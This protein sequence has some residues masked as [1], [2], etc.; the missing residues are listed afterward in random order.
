MADEVTAQTGDIGGTPMPREGEWVRR[1]WCVGVALGLIV[2]GAVMNVFYLFHHCPIDLSDDEAHYWM[3]AQQLDYG[4]YSKPPG[5]AFVIWV[6]Q[7]VGE[8]LGMTGDGSGA[9]LMPVIRMPAVLFGTLSG[10]LSW[11]LARRV[12]RDDRVG[13][14][15]IVLSAAV[16]MFAV[17]SLLIT[18]D[19][20]MY[21]CWA[22][23]VYCLWRVVSGQWSVA[24]GEGKGDRGK[25]IGGSGGRGRVVW[26]YAAGVCAAAGMMFK[27]VLIAVPL[28]AAV[29]AWGDG[30]MRRALKTWHALGAVAVMALSQVPVVVWNA[31]HGWVTFRHILTQ[32]GLS[33]QASTGGDSMLK[34]FGIF[35]GGQAGGLGGLLFVLLAIAVFLA[36]RA[37]WG[38]GATAKRRVDDLPTDACEHTRYVFL[39]SFLLPLW[40]FYFVMN[41]WK[42]TEVNWPAA[43]YFTGMALL[44][45]VVVRQWN[46]AVPKVRRDWRGWTT[47]AVIWGLILTGMALNLHR[48]YPWLATKLPPVT[49][50]GKSE[51]DKSWWNPR[52]WDP[53]AIKLRGLQARADGVQAIRREMTQG[54]EEPLII[55]GRYDTSSSLNFYLPGHPFVYCIMSSVGG[56]QNQFDV[57][58]GLSQ[59]VKDARGEHYLFEGRAA[60]LVG[61]DLNNPKVKALLERAF[62]VIGPREVVPVTYGGIVLKEVPVYR[63]WGFRQPPEQK[64]ASY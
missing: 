43:G 21:L 37:M 22:G 4:Y 60:I 44:A 18:I 54:G 11:A 45:G 33:G 24:S 19:S 10:L 12:F 59:R 8:M 62:T 2:L 47:A 41:F 3:W 52:K 29:G 49:S 16:P 35:L 40:G 34:R 20:P 13:L 28:C 14:A 17:G 1:R 31:N 63:A 58:P 46:S 57:W 51:Y 25:G 23:T 55:T 9:A 56:R 53:A 50:V 30:G 5:I 42:G 38:K 6:A 61:L 26:L 15:A 32:G 48:V 64:G 36:L 27:P 7:R 39:L